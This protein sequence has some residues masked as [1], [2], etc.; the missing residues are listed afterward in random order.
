MVPN[1]KC[2]QPFTLGFHIT[3]LCDFPTLFEIPSLWSFEQDNY[4]KLLQS[5]EWYKVSNR[6][7]TSWFWVTAKPFLTHFLKGFNS[8]FS[9]LSYFFSSFCENLILQFIEYRSLDI[10][11]KTKNFWI[12]ET[13]FLMWVLSKH[14]KI[15]YFYEMECT[16]VIFLFSSIYVCNSPTKTV[17]FSVQVLVLTSPSQHLLVLPDNAQ[18]TLVSETFNSNK[19]NKVII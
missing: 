16:N 5:F 7:V 15:M 1:P 6:F 17:H 11:F 3:I 9:Y 10:C 14:H 2:S 12:I 4:I 19:S 13:S 18:I 8:R